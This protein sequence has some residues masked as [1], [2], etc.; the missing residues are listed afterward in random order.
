M[1]EVEIHASPSLDGVAFTD[2]P[3]TGWLPSTACW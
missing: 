2:L 3:H 1:I